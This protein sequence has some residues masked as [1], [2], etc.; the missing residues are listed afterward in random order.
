MVSSFSFRSSRLKWDKSSFP[1]SLAF[2]TISSSKFDTFIITLALQFGRFPPQ[3]ESSEL[4]LFSSCCRPDKQRDVSHTEWQ[5]K[6]VR[7]IVK[8]KKNT[9]HRKLCGFVLEKI[10]HWNSFVVCMF[11][12]CAWEKGVL[13]VWYCLFLTQSKDQ[14]Q[15]TGFTQ[16]KGRK[17]LINF[18]V[19]TS[20]VFTKEKEI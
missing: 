1:F 18:Q 19:I 20:T 7:Y 13:F 12:S 10:T 2:V 6:Y 3:S 11:V 9:F 8:I 16:H 4:S 15:N 5:T 17:F 14:F